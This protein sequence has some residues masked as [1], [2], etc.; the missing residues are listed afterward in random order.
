MFGMIGVVFFWAGVWDGIGYL[1]YLENPWLSIVIGGAMLT[2]SQ[3]IFKDPDPNLKVQRKTNAILHKVSKHP[4]KHEFHIKYYDKSK[5]KHFVIKGN[6]ME[7]IEKGFLLMYQKGKE[8]FIPL[9]RVKEVL[10]KGKTI[11]KT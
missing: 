8:I 4:N 1:P 10:H 9:H 6:H 7:D 3:F 5:K 11:H 2:L